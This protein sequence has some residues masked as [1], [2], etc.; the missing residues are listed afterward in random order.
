MPAPLPSPAQS[1]GRRGPSLE[2][3]G[4]PGPHMPPR[5]QSWVRAPVSPLPSLSGPS[6]PGGRAL[7]HAAQSLPWTPVL[8]HSAASSPFLQVKS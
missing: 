8:V 5:R 4:R 7:Y 2:Q 6:S 3:G 1:T